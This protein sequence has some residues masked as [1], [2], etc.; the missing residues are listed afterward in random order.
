MDLSRKAIITLW[1]IG[2]VIAVVAIVLIAS[3]TT[4]PT[5]SVGIKVRFGA[6]QDEVI[7]EGLNFKAPFIEKIVKIDCKTKKIETSSESSTKDMQT[8]N[9][10]IVVNYNV[11][12]DTANKLYQTVGKEYEDILIKPAMLESI[13]SAMAQYTAEELITKRA[14]TSDKILETLKAKLDGKGFEITG[15]NL[16]NVSFSEAYNNA[17]EAKA[18]AQQATEKA[19]AELEK[20]Q[21][22][23]EKKIENAKADAEVMKYQNKEIT[24]KTLALKELEIKEQLIKKW[25]GNFP[26]TM[27]SD[28][29]A[30]LFNLGK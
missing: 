1:I 15:F 21:I 13:K 29:I 11:L 18:V 24:D 14:D 27:L 16:T 17:I 8:V 7:A 5:G 9:A 3:I 26:S 19:K 28:N 6:V 25:S 4:V 12:K 23:N 22:D 2:G 10:T 20:A 30:G